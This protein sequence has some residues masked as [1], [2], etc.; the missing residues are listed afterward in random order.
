VVCLTECWVNQILAGDCQLVMRVYDVGDGDPMVDR[1]TLAARSYVA[2]QQARVFEG[3][4][5]W[6]VKSRFS[7]EVI[8]ETN[9]A[10]DGYLPYASCSS[11]VGRRFKMIPV[12]DNVLMNCNSFN[13]TCTDKTGID[14]RN[15][16]VR[17]QNGQT[18]IEPG[19]F[20]KLKNGVDHTRT[21]IDLVGMAVHDD[22]DLGSVL[23]SCGKASLK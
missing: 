11:F 23:E 20:N 19:L 5:G 4:Y 3:C 1:R 2:K 14:L 22:A 17:T 18:R 9:W 15:L 21:A 12:S 6:Q 7:D 10:P 8:L 13:I 16:L